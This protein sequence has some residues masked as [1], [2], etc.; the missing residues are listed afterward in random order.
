[1]SGRKACYY[2]PE[3]LANDSDRRRHIE[4]TP[5]CAAAQKAALRRAER[6]LKAE[7]ES[8]AKDRTATRD[9]RRK[10][11]V[12][13]IPDVDAAG[14]TPAQPAPPTPSARAEPTAPI[15]QGPE[16]GVPKLRRQGDLYVE[17]FP[18]PSAGAPISDERLPP[19]DLEAYMRSSGRLGDPKTFRTADVLMTTKLTDAAKDRHLKSEVVSKHVY[20]QWFEAKYLFG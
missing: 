6:E 12:E 18:H 20:G 7:C 11:A 4:R 5:R 3:V 13:E 19:I 10:V 17:A 14:A 15:Q 1:L 16:P 2:C 8:N 9:K